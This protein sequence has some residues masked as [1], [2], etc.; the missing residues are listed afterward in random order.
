M[1]SWKRTCLVLGF[2][3]IGPVQSARS[4][5]TSGAA[6]AAAGDTPAIQVGLTLFADYTFTVEPESIDVD[7]NRFTPNAFNIGRAYLNVTGNISP[8]IA[9]RITPDIARET[10]PGSSVNGSLTFR[11]KYAYGQF[12]LDKW[13]RRGSFARIGMQQTPWID[14]I[15]SIYRYRFQGTMMEDREGMLSSA[16]AG[17]TFHYPFGD[18]YGDIHVGFYN[19][20][21]YNQAEL[22]DQK[23]LMARITIRP[24]P[25]RPQVRGLRVTGFY[26]RD[27]YVKD[28]ER[29]RGIAGLTYEHRYVNAGLNYL[30]ASDRSHVLGPKLDRNGFSVWATPKAPMGH[31]WEGLLRFDHLSQ[32][33]EM[34]S[35]KGERNRMIG[36][37]AYW[38]Q[39][40]G[41]RAAAILLDYER[42]NNENF[43]P[44]K[45]DERRWAVHTL[46][47]F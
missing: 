30:T 18:N 25:T 33:Q 4:Q 14:F 36:G 6:P 29:N 42:V 44:L 31:G 3:A 39:Q 46:F 2:V 21:G 38:F 34:T 15:E 12:N 13:M 5:A 45:A 40:R 41:P 17:A 9:F 16:D 26:D 10:T 43:V 27:A 20:D 35:R 19:G 1:P 22:S 23:A 37:I 11:L 32:E 47:S 8:A 7:G 28:A 24:F